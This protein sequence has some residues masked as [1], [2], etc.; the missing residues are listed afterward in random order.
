MAHHLEIS[1]PS[2]LLE[3]A[4]EAGVQCSIA[5]WVIP[6]FLP[7]LD[8]DISCPLLGVVVPDSSLVSSPANSQD[9]LSVAHVDLG[10]CSGVN[11]RSVGH[12]M[13]RGCC[14][15]MLSFGPILLRL[16]RLVLHFSV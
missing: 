8:H 9:H 16:P 6:P 10:S 12:P 11:Y 3:P 4:C 15:G 14:L 7:P 1:V 5:S 13:A 2:W